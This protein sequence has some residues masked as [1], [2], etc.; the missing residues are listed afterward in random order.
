MIFVGP[1]KFGILVLKWWVLWQVHKYIHGRSL[2]QTRLMKQTNTYVYTLRQMSLSRLVIRGWHRGSV[3]MHLRCGV[4]T[5]G[6]V[7]VITKETD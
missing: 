6:C 5:H 4:G 1:H 2:P 3:V 7:L